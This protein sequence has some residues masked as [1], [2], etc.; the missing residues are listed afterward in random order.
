MVVSQSSPNFIKRYLTDKI[1][2]PSTDSG[3]YTASQIESYRES[4]NRKLRN[5]IIWSVVATIIFNLLYLLLLTTAGRVPKTNST[6]DGFDDMDSEISNLG[7]F[8][9]SSFNDDFC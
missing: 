5:A 2:L 6:S 9:S 3:T 8:D 1:S 7:N 4:L